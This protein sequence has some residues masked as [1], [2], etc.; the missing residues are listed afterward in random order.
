MNTSQEYQKTSF[1]QIDRIVTQINKKVLLL[2]FT[3]DTKGM[4]FINSLSL[5]ELA[6]EFA[7][8]ISV[9]YIKATESSDFLKELHTQTLPVTLIYKNKK[10]VDLIVGILPKKEIRQRIINHIK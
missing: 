4:S 9:Y 2:S 7:D 5:Q 3:D 8:T 6:F 10:I 1:H